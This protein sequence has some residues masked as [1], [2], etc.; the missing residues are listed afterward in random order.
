MIRTSVPQNPWWSDALR[1]SLAADPRGARSPLHSDPEAVLEDAIA[2]A[3]SI[4]LGQGPTAALT[5][6]VDERHRAWDAAAER[7]EPAGCWLVGLCLVRGIGTE[8]DP[9]TGL[10]LLRASAEQRFAPALH[11]LARLENEGLQPWLEPDPL[12]ALEHYRDAAAQGYPPSMCNLGAALLEGVHLPQDLTAGIDW[13]RRAAEAGNTVA[14]I[15]LGALFADGEL[16]PEDP[17]EAARWYQRAADR[18]HAGALCLLGMC[19]EDGLGVVRDPRKAV[20]CYRKAAD[21]G[22]VEAQLLLGYCYE[23][24]NGVAPDPTRAAL[25]YQ[26]AAEAGNP[27]AQVALGSCYRHGAGLNV[28]PE[29]AVKWFA[30]AAEQDDL[31]GLFQL[32]QCYTHGFGVPVD[33]TT[34]V[35]LYRRCVPGEHPDA[36]YSLGVAY[37]RGDG[38]ERNLALALRFFEKA[39]SLGSQAAIEALRVQPS[40]SDDPRA[41]AAELLGALLDDERHA[42]EAARA[43]ALGVMEAATEL[44]LAALD[45][46]QRQLTPAIEGASIDRAGIAA[47]VCGAL[48]EGGAD[49][50]IA[51]EPLLER[52]PQVLA[53][54]R[55]YLRRC[56][57]RH[58][59]QTGALLEDDADLAD[60]DDGS[61]AAQLLADVSPGAH[62]GTVEHDEEEL[63]EPEIPASV[64][65]WV[66]ERHPDQAR[67]WHALDFW[68]QPAIAMLSRA[69]ELRA[70]L[71]R[72]VFRD[73]LEVLRHEHRGAAYLWQLIEVLD[74]EPL[75]VLDPVTRRGFRLR[76]SGISD[77]FQLQVLLAARLM[78]DAEAGMLSGVR[79]SSAA[80]DV[81]RGDGPQQIDETFVASWELFGWQALR[82]D[83]T[84]PD[85]LEAPDHH[86]PVDDIPAAIP[87]FEGVRTVLL[88]RSPRPRSW[89]IARMF[90]ALHASIELEAVL[91]ASEVDAILQRMRTPAS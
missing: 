35:E 74:D 50:E 56:R 44:D 37:S 5:E 9:A 91:G 42:F 75:L 15:N 88:G 10:D 84:L 41:L 78:G 11:S 6:R 28:D 18:G 27:H 60:T 73:T 70:S 3:L 85:P 30:L 55:D 40:S 21:R 38:V 24:G 69:E 26:R 14:Q 82:S 17:V 19:Y 71:E 64:A 33:H 36:I 12:R 63:L 34:A 90:G 87:D 46:L 22:D 72:E 59:E 65:A 79:P 25:W 86:V 1:Q 80:L 20:E 13:L 29:Q 7:G 43:A 49:P 83:S 54:A 62:G 4:D 61:R 32:A 39:A 76:I 89:S 51:L 67:A 66:A 45:D 2:V 48:V 77:N 23:E 57:Q 16:V 52:L 81:A 53:G 47:L 58:L 31:E 68:C 8:P